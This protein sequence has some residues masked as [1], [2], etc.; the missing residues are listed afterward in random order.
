MRP[1]P[2]SSV[3]RKKTTG[4]AIGLLCLAVLFVFLWTRQDDK[5]ERLAATMAKKR[6]QQGQPE[7]A[8]E[9]LQPLLQRE[10]VDGAVCYLAAQSAFSE[11]DYQ[12]A[13]S[14]VCSSSGGS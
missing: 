1:D 4:L 13:F 3:G 2:F 8:L 5:A 9:L 11:E 12:S 7:I 6:L 10:P 14:G